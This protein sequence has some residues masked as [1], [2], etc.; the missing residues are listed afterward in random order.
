MPEQPDQLDLLALFNHGRI[1]IITAPKSDLRAACEGL[2]EAF[3][4]VTLEDAATLAFP[5]AGLH[6]ISNRPQLLHRI[7]LP[8][9]LLRLMHRPK[10]DVEELRRR[11]ASQETFFR[12]SEGLLHGSYL[13]DPYVGP[14]LA[15]LSPPAVWALAV[16]RSG[17]L[18]VTLSRQI[19]RTTLAS[20]LLSTITT[21]GGEE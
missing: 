3:R 8:Q 19:S 5:H 15:A 6:V 16:P 17:Q 10:L 14:L 18:I 13:F 21:Q 12:S 2:L 11:G 7:K 1:N 20:N 9:V 4:S